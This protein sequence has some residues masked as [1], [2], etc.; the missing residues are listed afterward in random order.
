[1]V[2]RQYDGAM[3]TG[4]LRRMSPDRRRLLVQTAAAEFATAGYE[5]ASLNKIIK[6]CGLSKSSFYHMIDSKRALFELVVQDLTEQVAATIDLPEP[7]SF[8]G[9]RFWSH[10]EDLLAQLTAVAETNEAL[11][12]LGRMFYLPG[13]PDE[14]GA[15]VPTA[16]ASI[17]SWVRSV[18]E[19]GRASGVVREDLPVSL[20][21]RLVFA[22]LQAL[23]EWT[24]THLDDLAPEDFPEI[25][26]AQLGAI[27][28]LL[29]A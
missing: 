26:G 5:Q 2:H 3:P 11:T 1:M 22:V 13:I 27:R 25:V 10:I 4:D 23:D 18:L 16:Q 20:Q 8:A 19:V 7:Q 9:S 24:V 28:R 6:A 14:D 15:A 17:E 12:A 21:G 29:K